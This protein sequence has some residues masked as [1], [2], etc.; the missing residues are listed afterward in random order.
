M[1]NLKGIFKYIVIAILAII[2]AFI[3]V[4]SVLL[5]KS[6]FKYS[7]AI[8]VRFK[9]LGPIYSSMPVY[10]KGYKIGKTKRVKPSEDYKYT[11]VQ[12]I[13]YPENLSL[14]RNIGA[15]VKKLDNGKDYIELTYPDAPSLSTLTNNDT[16]E[17]ATA[18]DIESFMSAQI[19]SG[20]FSSMGD[21]MNK[22]LS[23]IEIT[24]NELN[25]FF[26]DLRV[27]LQEN[28]P[29]IKM[30]TDATL[31]ILEN[32]SNITAS[33]DDTLS[34]DELK[35]I[36]KNMSG[37]SSDIKETTENVLT[38]SQNINKA[39][40]DLDKTM[41][42]IDAT[43]EEAHKTAKNA[44]NI[45]CGI[46]QLLEKRFAGIRLFFGQPTSPKNCSNCKINKC[47]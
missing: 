42:K 45:S 38:I 27:V 5:W 2:L 18:A 26:K 24:S 37:S 13:L 28:R 44:T 10:Y 4:E 3:V 25:G 35:N 11:I 6:N 23:S 34:G 32:I 12:V 46:K 1:E 14:P 22:T 8:K 16:I 17:G 41:S 47:K 9:E 30:S 15:K 29:N 20:V 43:I 19:E 39:T 7:M 40:K 33:I 21:N 31:E 36:T